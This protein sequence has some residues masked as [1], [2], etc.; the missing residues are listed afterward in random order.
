MGAYERGTG[1]VADL[2]GAGG[3]V[4]E[5][6]SAAG[7]QREPAF[8]RAA[9]GAEQR[10]ASAGIDIEV[11]PVRGLP[12]RDVHGDASAVVS[13]IGQGGRPVAAARCR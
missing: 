1:D 13:R 2:A 5:G 11:T 9:Q 4:L 8:A 12:D 10:V 3:D 7:E 6:A